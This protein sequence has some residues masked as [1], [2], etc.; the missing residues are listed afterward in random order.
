MKISLARGS[1]PE[2]GFPIMKKSSLPFLLFSVLFC[3]QG[4]TLHSQ[5]VSTVPVG[6]TTI[7]IYG[8]GGQGGEAFSYLG[9]PMHHAANFRSAMTAKA[10]NSI[11]CANASWTANAFANTHF[12]MIMSGDNTGMSATITANTADTLITAENLSSILTGNE[13]FAIHKYTTI[14]DVFGASNSAGLKASDGPGTADN[15]L[16][17]TGS[18]SFSSYYYK[19][20][21]LIGGTGWRGAASSSV[22]ASGT[23]IPYG[24]GIIVVRRESADLKVPVMGSVF[25]DDVVT[26]V[27]E[28]FNWKTAS[29]PVDVTLAGFFGANNEAGLKGSDGPGTADNV[30]VFNRSGNFTTYYYKNA[31]LIGG[32]G[33][34]SAASSSTDVANTVIAAPG[35][36]FMIRRT[37]AAFN[38][39]EKSPL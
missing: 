17:Q 38:L 28:G 30:L 36:M 8:T 2:V 13:N 6:Y 15:I 4:V 33:W 22:D 3:L 18:N 29:L 9:V 39:T 27:E 31:G 26:P 5:S 16:I 14:A 7:T 11:T 35:S 20:A 21:G 19:N 32:T 1:Q 12:V 25:A 37:E 34:R 23:I 10:D 24:S